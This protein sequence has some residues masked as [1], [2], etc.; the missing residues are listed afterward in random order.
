LPPSP[1]V[2]ALPRFLTLPPAA[3]DARAGE[4]V[5]EST[6]RLRLA[7]R[8]VR[9]FLASPRDGVLTFSPV[10][11]REFVSNT[12]DVRLTFDEDAHGR[13]RGLLLRSGSTVEKG[14]R[15]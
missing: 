9:L 13:T 6:M 8:D 10:S 3:L 7:R 14:V 15:R 5:L 1:S 11:D 2:P 4:Y 12:A